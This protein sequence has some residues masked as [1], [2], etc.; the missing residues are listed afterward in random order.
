MK[1]A[2]RGKVPGPDANAV[3][4]FEEGGKEREPSYMIVMRVGQKQVCVDRRFAADRIAQGPQA[5]SR[6][7]N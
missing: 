2:R 7:E 5:R 6:V 4:F 3:L 1:T